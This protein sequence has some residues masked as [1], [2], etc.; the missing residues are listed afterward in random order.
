M[1]ESTEALYRVQRQDI[2]RAG[3]V[4]ADAFQQDA[5]WKL[6][7]RD[8]ATIALRGALFESALKHCL[9]YGT[10]RATSAQLEGIAG[11]V[12]GE[13]ADMTMWRLV[14]SGAVFSGLRAVRR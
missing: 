1:T 12:P 5:L 3:V 11:W 4:L 7:F 10:V 2:R 6:F 9:R 8:E 13:L 14:R